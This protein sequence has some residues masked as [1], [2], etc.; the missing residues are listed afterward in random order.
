M[1]VL[2]RISQ[3]CRN[4]MM[5]TSTLWSAINVSH[6]GAVKPSLFLQ[7]PFCPIKCTFL[8]EFGPPL[9]AKFMKSP[10]DFAHSNILP[11]QLVETIGTRE[12]FCH[13][14]ADHETHISLSSNTLS[15]TRAASSIV[16]VDGANAFREPTECPGRF[17]TSFYILLQG[18][19]V[20]TSGWRALSR[21]DTFSSCINGRLIMIA[22]A[23]K[24]G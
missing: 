2:H 1:M 11:W 6:R 18:S 24:A 19:H 9:R 5:S 22:A 10:P 15:R 17:L 4:K 14:V 13:C 16:W 21:G 20:T 8:M 7:V 12:L 3:M 23:F